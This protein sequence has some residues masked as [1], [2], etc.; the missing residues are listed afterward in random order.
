MNRLT[1]VRTLAGLSPS[2]FELLVVAIPDAAE[3]ISRHGTVREQAAELIRWAESSTGCKLP[4]VE[5]ALAGFLGG[6]SGGS[7]CT[8]PGHVTPT[9]GLGRLDPLIPDLP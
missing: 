3:Q 4:A 9:D 5:E 1:L 6:S 7:D 2:D 8:P